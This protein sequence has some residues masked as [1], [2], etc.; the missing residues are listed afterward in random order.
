[1][2]TGEIGNLEIEKDDRKRDMAH[3][4]AATLDALALMGA[5][6]DASTF[7]EKGVHASISL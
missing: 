3:T 6:N 2:S 1:M 4:L 7:A 5:P